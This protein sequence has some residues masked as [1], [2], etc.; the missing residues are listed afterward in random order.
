MQA[1]SAQTRRPARSGCAARGRE[2]QE[3]LLFRVWHD[4]CSR[5]LDRTAGEDAMTKSIPK[6]QQWMSTSPLAIERDEPLRRAHDIMR[7]AAVRHLPVLEH[8][9]LVGI[10]SLHDMH[11]I[12]TLQDVDP[13]QV[14]VDEAMTTHPYF[15]SPD[16]PLDEVVA[17]MAEHKF[18]AAV[19]MQNHKVVGMFT[20]V[21]ALRAFAELLHGR[22]AA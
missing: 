8:G 13:E 21:D 15:V 18:G 7:S 19:V 4:E 12:E 9:K 14:H 20:T 5:R 3:R 16:A 10:I 1:W 17:E 2:A 22:L 11:L 6:V